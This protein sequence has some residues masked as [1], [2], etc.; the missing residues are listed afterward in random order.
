MLLQRSLWQDPNTTTAFEDQSDSSRNT[1][2]PICN[3]LL[4]RKSNHDLISARTTQRTVVFMGDLKSQEGER[5]PL[6]MLVREIIQDADLPV[7][8]CP[9]EGLLHCTTHPSPTRSIRILVDLWSNNS[10]QELRNTA[11]LAYTLFRKL[12]DSVPLDMLACVYPSR[13]NRKIYTVLSEKIRYS[14][15]D[16]HN[17]TY[18]PR[19]L[20]AEER[21]L[22]SAN[23]R[24]S[25]FSF[26]S[27]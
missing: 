5:K 20:S 2:P 11:S 6:R 25:L 24:A 21:F 27:V 10:E 7:T 1:L 13:G 22:S 16:V 8:L 9:L 4:H 18:A 17:I 26:L 19:L 3:T 23:L 14:H 15:S 12:G